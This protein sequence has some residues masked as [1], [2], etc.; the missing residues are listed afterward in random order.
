LPLTLDIGREA[1][2]ERR[3][4]QLYKPSLPYPAPKGKLIELKEKEMQ[5]EI[6]YSRTHNRAEEDHYI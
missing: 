1:R 2:R 4:N 5:T 3:N 6:K